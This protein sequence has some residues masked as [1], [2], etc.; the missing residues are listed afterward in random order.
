MNGATAEIFGRPCL[1]CDAAVSQ[2][3]WS[4]G[5]TLGVQ[6][7][8]LDNVCRDEDDFL[9][10]RE[11][12][13]VTH[14]SL[15]QRC[16]P[17]TSWTS[18]SVKPNFSLVDGEKPP[19]DCLSTATTPAP[20]PAPVPNPPTGNPP[21]NDPPP[22]PAPTP[23]PTPSPIPPSN[24]NPTDTSADVGN[25]RGGDDGD[26]DGGL[27]GGAIAGIAIG[28]FA[29]IAI[30]TVVVMSRRKK[31]SQYSVEKGFVDDRGHEQ[32]MNNEYEA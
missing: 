14:T 2:T 28:C 9:T 21:T 4:P 27:S 19:D 26:D 8:F 31:A 15:C 32:V 3:E 12:R 16:D 17:T 22:T 20:T 30:A 25:S 6:Q 24:S 10:F 5:P 7:C 18:W 1:V 29:G 23:S 11:S 13:Q